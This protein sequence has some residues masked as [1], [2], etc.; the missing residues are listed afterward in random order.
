MHTKAALTWLLS[1]RRFRVNLCCTHRWTPRQFSSVHLFTYQRWTP[2]L[3][4]PVDLKT[5]LKVTWWNS[6]GK[7]AWIVFCRR[8]PRSPAIVSVPS[9]QREERQREREGMGAIVAVSAEGRGENEH[10]KMTAKNSA[11]AVLR[12][13]SCRVVWHLLKRTLSPLPITWYHKRFFKKLIKATKPSLYCIR[14]L[15][16]WWFS[17]LQYVCPRLFSY[18][19]SKLAICGQLRGR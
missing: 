7:N 18:P 4:S 19:N 11:W 12:D 16:I 14:I 17:A 13:W 5:P 9:I 2:S 6:K 10:N 1:F 15:S 8:P 3:S